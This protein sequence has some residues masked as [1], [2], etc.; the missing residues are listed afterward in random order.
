MGARTKEPKACTTSSRRIS[1]AS[2]ADQPHLFLQ[3]LFFFAN[4]LATVFHS[5]ATPRRGPAERSPTPLCRVERYLLGLGRHF[6]PL[7]RPLDKTLFQPVVRLP[8]RMG[9][10]LKAPARCKVEA[11]MPLSPHLHLDNVSCDRGAA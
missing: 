9:F 10:R 11:S 3:I 6:L 8:H 1:A 7:P 4:F 2:C 5:V